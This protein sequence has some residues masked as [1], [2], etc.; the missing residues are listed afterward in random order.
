MF[1]S[2]GRA[3]KFVKNRE[4]GTWSDDSFEVTK[5]KEPDRIDMVER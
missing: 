3:S 1:D 5:G 2:K 4:R